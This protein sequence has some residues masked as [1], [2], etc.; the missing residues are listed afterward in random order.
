MHTQT[1]RSAFAVPAGFATLPP[2]SEQV[3]EESLA[4]C[5][6]FNDL[7][8]P[9][10]GLTD[11]LN[12]IGQRKS[13]LIQTVVLDLSATALKASD[14]YGA[15]RELTVPLTR[16]HISGSLKRVILKKTGERYSCRGPRACQMVTYLVSRLKAT[17]QERNISV[18]YVETDT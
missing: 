3:R 10:E 5:Y 1:G 18:S 14:L 6:G 11:F 7:R 16:L 4:I 13:A 9:Y 17:K 8:I 15:A 2:V 12:A